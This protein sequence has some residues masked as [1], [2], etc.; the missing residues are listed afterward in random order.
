MPWCP[1]CGSEYR[2]G[3]ATCAK[4][5]A[6]LVP[7][8]PEA[9]RRHWREAVPPF[10]WGLLGQVAG[11]LRHGTAAARLLC[12]HPSLLLLPLV[13]AVVN[14][15]DHRISS[16]LPM[17]RRHLPTG[18]RT[19]WTPEKGWERSAPLLRPSE[20]FRPLDAVGTFSSPAPTPSLTGVVRMA[21]ESAIGARELRQSDLL[22][23]IAVTLVLILPLPTFIASGYYRVVREAASGGEAQWEQF[24]PGVKHYFLRLL[25]YAAL[26]LVVLY[27]PG[28]LFAIHASGRALTSDWPLRLRDWWTWGAVPLAR[29]SLALAITAIVNDDVRLVTGIKRGVV[30]VY[31]R[32]L[33][34][35]VLLVMVGALEFLVQWPLRG[36]SYL[37][38]GRL[39]GIDQVR[40]LLVG[41][42]LG[43]LLEAAYAA[44]GVWF[45]V[46][47]FL[48]YRDASA[49]LWP[50]AEEQPVPVATDA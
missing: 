14:V 3:V 50:Q 30:V 35:L 4:C 29:F 24:F 21:Y 22:L 39:V 36:I 5:Q 1:Q 15:A 12:R 9:P 27:V 8:R 48:W 17:A 28:T 37:L 40:A 11:A 19:L 41:M 16:Y 26:L 20:L 31:R 38:E 10:A 46:A 7:E 42:P 45:C 25:A 6:G 32:L 33:T 34:A 49:R 2:E 43:M 44:V 18:S 47:A 23:S 13:I